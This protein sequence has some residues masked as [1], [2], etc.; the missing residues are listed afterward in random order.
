MV[1]VLLVLLCF[2]DAIAVVL[3]LLTI[4]LLLMVMAV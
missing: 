2:V 3:S 4:V 1:W